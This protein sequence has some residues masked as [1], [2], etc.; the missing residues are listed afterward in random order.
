MNE[1]AGFGNPLDYILFRG[2]RKPVN[3]CYPL[4]GQRLKRR[5]RFLVCVPA[6]GPG[7]RHRPPA[8]SGRSLGSCGL[9]LILDAR[10]LAPAHPLASA[11]KES[12]RHRGHAGASVR[13]TLSRS[14]GLLNRALGVPGSKRHQIGNEHLDVTLDC[15]TSVPSSRNPRDDQA[16]C[17]CVLSSSACPSAGRYRPKFGNSK[18]LGTP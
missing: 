7:D 17:A 16:G 15:Q 8:R 5:R 12:C 4:V 1:P 2:R 3:S 6:T 13:L 18:S 11:I 14:R 10:N 9:T